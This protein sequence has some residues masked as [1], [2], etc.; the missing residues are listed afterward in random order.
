[1]ASPLKPRMGLHGIVCVVAAVSRP[2][3][4]CRCRPVTVGLSLHVTACHGRL[5]MP[6]KNVGLSPL[7]LL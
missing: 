3:T 5:Q 7:C 6:R 4:A 1:M 2:V